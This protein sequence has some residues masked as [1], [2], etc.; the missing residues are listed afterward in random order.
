MKQKLLYGLSALAVSMVIL[1]S[2]TAIGRTAVTDL[3]GIA[4]AQSGALWKNVRDAAVGDN[5][6]DGIMA[7]AL[8]MFDGTNFDRARGDIT[9]GLDVDVTRLAGAVTPT[10]AFSN[11]TNALNV[12]SLGGIFNGTTWD[13]WRGQTSPIQGVTLLNSETTSAADTTLTKTLT[14]VA[15]TRIHIYKLKSNCSAGASSLSITDNAV[16]IYS[17]LAGNTIPQVPRSYDE[18]WPTGLTISTGS[19]AVVSILTCGAGNT[20]TLTLE[21]D[22]F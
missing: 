14:G 6:T 4:V 18:T 12:F 15:G 2:L 7:S 22:Q 5:L 13:R 11:P 9:N 21:A 16:G 1:I 10:D 3:A 8:M 20:S 17:T 19:N